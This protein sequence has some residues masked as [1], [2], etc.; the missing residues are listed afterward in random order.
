MAGMTHLLDEDAG[1]ISEGLTH[2]ILIESFLLLVL[3]NNQDLQWDIFLSYASE[4]GAEVVRPLV[5]LLERRGCHVWFDETQLSL[6]DS[7]RRKIND[8]LAHSRFG[9]VVISDAFLAKKWPQD[10]VN[11]LLARETDGTKVVLPILHRITSARLASVAPLLADR[12]AVSTNKGLD[13]VAD[14]ILR[15][16][17]GPST[18][19]LAE[20]G[21]RLVLVVE[22]Q[23]ILHRWFDVVEHTTAAKTFDVQTYVRDESRTS[24]LWSFVRLLAKVARIEEAI[25]VTARIQDHRQI[26]AR[27]EIARSL[28]EQERFDEA[29]QFLPAEEF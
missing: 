11:G 4:D 22:D 12:I 18:D 14:E 27:F 16:L 25:E 20:E 8:G 6:G 26:E 9:V 28:I 5:E 29:K 10:E 19:R 23:R 1:G 2:H 17:G 15:V 13:S 7:L 21:L 24:V 3:T